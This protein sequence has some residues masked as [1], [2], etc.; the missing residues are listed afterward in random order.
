MV[1]FVAYNGW[2]VARLET[3]E[4]APDEAVYPSQRRLIDSGNRIITYLDKEIGAVNRYNAYN[5]VRFQ[6]ARNG[7]LP[8][9]Y[10][11]GLENYLR[12]LDYLVGQ[13]LY[14][15]IQDRKK[16]LLNK[17]S[18]GLSTTDKDDLIKYAKHLR[19]CAEYV[20]ADTP[21]RKKI[22]SS[23]TKTTCGRKRPHFLLTYGQ[24]LRVANHINGKRK[25]PYEK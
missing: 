21:P 12:L 20:D 4:A 2:V 16:I 25:E 10:M 11:C 18:W 17:V 1:A 8:Q 5:V 15:I 3:D 14:C 6:K 22:G 13:I 9:K 23:S 19:E 7:V 24:N